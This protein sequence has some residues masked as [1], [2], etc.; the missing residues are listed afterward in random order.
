MFATN[1]TPEVDAEALPEAEV[2][3]PMGMEDVLEIIV[4]ED[5]SITTHEDDGSGLPMEMT[6]EVDVI[7]F[8]ANLADVLGE[9]EL[10]VIGARIKTLVEADKE[11][12]KEWYDTLK[13]GLA[14]LGI[15]CP[16]D[17]A[18][19]GVR[20]ISHPLLLEAATQFQARAMAELLPPGG[21]V[22]TTTLGVIT[23]DVTAQSERIKDHMNYQLTVEDRTYYDERDQMLFLLAFTGSE[24]D[25]QYPDPTT[26]KVVSR[27]VRCDHFIVPYNTK[28]LE[29]AGRY[30]HEIHMTKN[31]YRRLVEAGFYSG[32]CLDDASSESE[33]A[34]LTEKL[35]ELDGQSK[36]VNEDDDDTDMVFYECHIDFDLPGYEDNIAL[37]YI[38]TVNRE[39]E[40]VVGLRRN[41]KEAD[42]YRRKRVWFSHKKFLPG[43]GFYGFGFLHCIGNLGEAATEILR[44]LLDSG[45]FAT[46]QG[47][48]KS[49]DCRLPGDVTLEPGVWIDTEMTAEELNRSFYTPPFKEP[50]QT[51]FSLLG[52]IVSTGQKFAATTE[53]MTGDAATTGPVGTMVAQIEQ[54]SKVFSGIHKRL[55]KAFGDEFIHI[56]EL[57]G[58]NLPEVYPFTV[59]GADRSVLKSDY[60]GRIDVVPVSDPNIFSSA[61]RLAMAQT[62][63]QLASSMPD[64][65]DRREAAI[66]LLNAMRFPNPEKIFPP[67]A[68]AV[69][70]DPIVEGSMVMMGKPIK[71]FLD[72]H[73]QAHSMVHQMQVQQLPEQHR[74]AMMAHIFEHMA[75]TQYLTF[76]QMGVPLPP[77]EFYPETG[78]PMYPDVPA[79]IETQIALK[80]AQVVQQMMQQQQA[81]AQ[82]QA[83]QEQAAAGGVSPEQKA[84]MEQEDFARKQ[85][86]KDA[87][88]QADQA[89]KDA[90]VVADVDRRDALAGLSP[91]LVKQAEEFIAQT[92]VQ[93]SPRELA[94]LS[95]ALGKPFTDVVSALS[96]MLMQG[97]G[98]SQFS[99]TADL[100]GGGPRFL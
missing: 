67:K 40:Q 63:L 85:Q 13:K 20:R 92:G 6:V 74:P 66:G 62:A 46:L 15:Y 93:M 33:A 96:R 72:Q 78:T 45:A 81:Q 43:F 70:T 99:Q 16:D 9:D 8:G 1:Q 98:G 31:E 58:E 64:L 76:A 90:A 91:Q 94:V 36:P 68:E 56:A 84:A 83:Q 35:T 21:P 32:C 79:P 71:A 87:A 28:N 17:E 60:D 55:H 37:P 42:S 52:S 25:K 69:R 14:A 29:T 51:L 61:Q 50:S 95:K 38:I 73:H 3:M 30:T 65:A 5:G 53:T 97:Q 10:K 88:F 39:T 22:K 27:W 49:K 86:M 75:M 82:A 100:H 19:V 48:F 24:F 34:P 44:I 26:G 47:G 57:N 59:A 54:G 12:R 2:E 77:V 18:D 23:P 41:W 7:P 89:R 80:A 11:T 4:G